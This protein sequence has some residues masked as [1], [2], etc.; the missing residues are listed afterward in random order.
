MLLR[1]LLSIINVLL[2]LVM[3]VAIHCLPLGVQ[4]V[5]VFIKFALLLS[6]IRGSPQ[7]LTW[8]MMCLFTPQSL[9]FYPLKESDVSCLLAR[10]H[11]VQLHSVLVVQAARCALRVS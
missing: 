11:L 3:L 8:L 10:H 9:H 5:V 1:I 6:K 2:P 7:K 4:D